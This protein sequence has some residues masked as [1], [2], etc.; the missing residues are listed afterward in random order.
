[1]MDGW[2]PFE[3]FLLALIAGPIILALLA[4]GV[5]APVL[6]LMSLWRARSGPEPYWQAFRRCFLTRWRDT[7]PRLMKWMLKSP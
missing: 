5:L 4:F 6:A 3:D 1:M 7:L 2:N